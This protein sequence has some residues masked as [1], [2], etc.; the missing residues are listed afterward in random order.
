MAVIVVAAVSLA[1]LVWGQQ[2]QAAQAAPSAQ[3]LAKQPQV[4]SKAEAEALMAVFNA[5]DPDTRL[6]AVD[7][8]LTKFKDTEFKAVALQVAAVTYQQKN[9]FENM[10]AYA[11]RTLEA[12]PHSY[13]AMLMLASGIAQRTREFDLD[14]EE[15]LARVE[16]YVRSAQEVLK[17]ALKPNPNLTDEQWE[18]AKKDFDAQG[19]E[20]LG[21]AALARKKYDVTIQEFKTAL[22]VASSPDPA[23]MV[24]LGAVYNMAGKHD[25]A[26]ALLD[27]LMAQS[28]VHPQIK[29]FAQAERAR[30][31]QM[32]S[33]AAKPA[34]QPQAGTA[35][36]QVEIK[37]P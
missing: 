19:H 3:P 36:P 25:E 8:L 11:E 26:I 14:R 34:D 2:P 23:T 24:R 7:T 16:K 5:P 30:A 9:D 6:K 17:T 22:E 21:L 12:D 13:Q 33:A 15:K 35:P 32:K 28:D 10:V 20:A 31:F 37:K 29:Q 27:K 1:A 18:A 4:K